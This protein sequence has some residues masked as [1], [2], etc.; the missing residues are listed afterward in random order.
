MIIANHI[1]VFIF[2]SVLV[3]GER[4]VRRSKP[5]M[6]CNLLLENKI[7][8]FEPN[9]FPGN[10]LE[11]GQKTPSE[12]TMQVERTRRGVLTYSMAVAW[13]TRK[14]G[15]SLC[16]SSLKRG[17]EHF[18]FFM[19]TWP[20]VKSSM[21]PSLGEYEQVETVDPFWSVM[22]DIECEDCDTRKHCFLVHRYGGNSDKR[23][24]GKMFI[25]TTGYAVFGYQTKNT[26]D[27]F[28]WTVHTHNIG[29]AMLDPANHI[30]LLSGLISCYF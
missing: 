5:K 19:K 28:D 7:L 23:N 4:H 6:C 2:L 13:R 20:G 27:L 16:I 21:Y 26:E 17:F 24:Y 25:D 9:Q 14:C 18:F 10:Q 8:S 11:P 12:Y 30:L 3:E 29:T 15:R 22:F 1:H